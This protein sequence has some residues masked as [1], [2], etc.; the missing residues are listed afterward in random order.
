MEKQTTKLLLG[1]LV[2]VISSSFS[3]AANDAPTEIEF[4]HDLLYFKD[5]RGYSS[6][7]NWEMENYVINRLAEIGLPAAPKF[8][9]S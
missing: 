8:L 1:V 2:F 3:I 9:K 7:S 5:L 4:L 6:S